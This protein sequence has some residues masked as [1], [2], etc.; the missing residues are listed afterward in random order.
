MARITS[1]ICTKRRPHQL[2][3]TNFSTDISSQLFQLQGQAQAQKPIQHSQ[4]QKG[5]L[6]LP[7]PKCRN[8]K[9]KQLNQQSIQ[10]PT[11]AQITHAEE[12][13]LN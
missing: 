12:K 8:T 10:K 4:R 9:F 5:R 13:A 3:Y 1:K 2:Q 6:L 11:R 7:P